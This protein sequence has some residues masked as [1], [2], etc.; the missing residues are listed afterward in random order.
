MTTT[1]TLGRF[2]LGA[3]VMTRGASTEIP[4]DDFF[5]AL[6]RHMACDWGDLDAHD[7]EMNEAAVQHG[8]RILSRYVTSQA[9]VF[10]VITE[11]DRS[12]TTFLLPDEY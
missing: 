8:G 11:H 4:Y 10:W 5:R 2:E 1:P 7:W 9:I 6:V 12:T 3:I